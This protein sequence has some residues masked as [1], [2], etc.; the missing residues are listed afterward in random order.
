M[1]NN[2]V[3]L[4]GL[5]AAALLITALC[6]WWAIGKRS[7]SAPGQPGTLP[8][9]PLAAAPTA[10]A[11]PKEP[12]GS[13]IEDSLDQAISRALGPE[14]ERVQLRA[15][16]L[17]TLPAPT[18]DARLLVP[19]RF[20]RG[21]SSPSISPDGSCVAF[22]AEVSDKEYD[23]YLYS[24]TTDTFTNLTEGIDGLADFPAFSPDGKSVL[25]SAYA[26]SGIWLVDLAT[27][28]KRLVCPEPNALAPRWS[29]DGKSAVYCDIPKGEIRVLDIA[30][31]SSKTLIEPAGGMKWCE[32][33]YS[34]D[35]DTV[36]CVRVGNNKR[37]LVLY[38]ISSNERR[39]VKLPH[40]IHAPQFSPDGK[41]IA[42]RGGGSG[43]DTEIY[44][45]DLQSG[46]T[47]QITHGSGHHPTWSPEGNS[48]AFV[49]RRKSG[50]NSVYEIP[51]DAAKPGAR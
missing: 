19:V 30:A 11:D 31:G 50:A 1:N 12:S 44:V 16:V 48:L 51:V 25:L 33:S 41:R 37:T 36:A 28:Q 49:S 38:N 23:I 32:A 35:G 20:D 8:T 3:K 2:R 47:T 9:T 7:G 34:P 22:C 27:Q 45:L 42:Y 46:V 17:A 15:R 10:E 4:L 40:N 43:A 21:Q 18:D 29:P 6:L 26:S 39:E 14:E 24:K 13:G 5:V